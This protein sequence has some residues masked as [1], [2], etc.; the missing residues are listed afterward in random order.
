MSKQKSNQGKCAGNDLGSG[1]EMSI[2]AF[3]KHMEDIASREA[4]SDKTRSTTPVR[5]ANLES[6]KT[7][8]RLVTCESEVSDVIFLKPGT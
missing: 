7:H 5:I 2:E 8:S 1:V 4:R 6:L 3:A